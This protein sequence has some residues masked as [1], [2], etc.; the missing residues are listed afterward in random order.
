MISSSQRPLPDNT[1]H[2]Q[3]TNIHAPGGIRT[4]DLSRRAALPLACSIMRRPWPNWGLSRQ[5]TTL[6]YKY[7]QLG[8][9]SQGPSQANTRNSKLNLKILSYTKK[10]QTYNI[11][12]IQFIIK[13]DTEPYK[14]GCI[15]KL[16][17]F[18]IL[19]TGGVI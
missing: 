19:R 9:L 15:A 4:Q 3:Q 7:S 6:Q 17:C 2:S 18:N 11:V 1:R 10:V 8:C 13:L 14:Q 5:K 12:R 16:H